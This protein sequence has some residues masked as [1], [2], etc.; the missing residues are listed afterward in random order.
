VTTPLPLLNN[1]ELVTVAWIASI[2]FLSAAM[3]GTQL[4]PDTDHQDNPAMWLQTGYV[5]VATVGGT[6]D[7]LLPVNRPVMEVKCWAAVPGSDKPPWLAARALGSVIQRA[8]LDRYTV[9]R[10]LTP[11]LNGVTYPT[12]VVQA[13]Y[14]A[15]SFRRV[16]DDPGDYACYQADL[17]LQWVTPGDQ[18]A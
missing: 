17:A 4:P 16:Y 2:P 18:L 14:F 8:V 12:A 15:Q 9:A 7:P 1:D 13:A 3:V 5:T 10:P 11:V 6:P